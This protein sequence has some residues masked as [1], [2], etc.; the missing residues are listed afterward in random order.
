MS[1]SDKQITT[2]KQILGNVD[3]ARQYTN[4]WI[5]NDLLHII[6]KLIN[7]SQTWEQLLYTSGGKLELSKCAIFVLQWEFTA[8]GQPFLIETPAI[9]PVKIVSSETSETF[10]VPQ[11][12]STDSFKYLGIKSTL[13]GS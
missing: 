6:T 10:L 3:D 2:I 4:D 7:A 12:K 8:E 13:T 9:D 11:M 1:S 5:D